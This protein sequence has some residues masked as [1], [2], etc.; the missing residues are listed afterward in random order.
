MFKKLLFISAFITLFQTIFAV[1]VREDVWLDADLNHQVY[2]KAKAYTSP[3][4]IH[5]NIYNSQHEVLYQSL[6][7]S[8]VLIS[9]NIVLT[10]AHVVESYHN[11]IFKFLTGVLAWIRNKSW[12]VTVVLE[13][14]QGERIEVGIDKQVYAPCHGRN[15]TG[16]CDIAILKLKHPVDTN[17]FKPAQI[18]QGLYSNILGQVVSSIGYGRFGNSTAGAID[19]PDGRKRYIESIYSYYANPELI[20]STYFQLDQNQK[21]MKTLITAYPMDPNHCVNCRAIQDNQNM[22][23]VDM[24]GRG[25]GFLIDD[26]KMTPFYG[27]CAAGDS[28]GPHFNSNGELVSL[29]SFQSCGLTVENGQRI[30]MGYDADSPVGIPEIRDWITQTVHQLN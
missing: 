13:D 24:M 10:A 26:Q 9:D 30:C 5:M 4:A 1:V 25:A 8:G 29:T 15:Q 11:P 20:D 28:G 21:G 22:P 12:E 6:V 14:D 23:L 2:E 16:V 27:R 3:V 18:F 7:G 19:E 17:R